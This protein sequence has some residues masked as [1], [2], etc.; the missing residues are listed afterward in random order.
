MFT[1]A[2]VGAG[3]MGRTHLNNLQKMEDVKIDSICDPNPDAS[4]LARD[5]QA[6]YYADL[7][8]YP[9]IEIMDGIIIV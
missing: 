6:A 8:E 2:V 5:V 9:S 3:G 1:V 4:A 7:D